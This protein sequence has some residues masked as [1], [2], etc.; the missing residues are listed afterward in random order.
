MCACVFVCAFVRVC[1]HCVCMFEINFVY[2]Y[3]QI[4]G[5]FYGYSNI[6]TEWISKLVFQELFV[7]FADELHAHAQLERDTQPIALSE[8][9]VFFNNNKNPCLHTLPTTTLKAFF[10]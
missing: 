4:G 3:T 5:A 1:V 9:G 2:F 10:L 7:T 6:P 8:V